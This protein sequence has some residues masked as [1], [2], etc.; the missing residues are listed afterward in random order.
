VVL[1]GARL[2]AGAVV[3][4]SIV[5]HGAK[6]GEGARVVG[7]SVVGDDEEVAPGAL[8]DCARQPSRCP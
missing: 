7:C 4:E 5:G 2:G 8:L 3:E 1:D 6:V